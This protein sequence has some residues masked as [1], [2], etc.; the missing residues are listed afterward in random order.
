MAAYK[1]K[2]I[3]MKPVRTQP[4]VNTGQFQPS[5]VI[6][7]EIIFAAILLYLTN[8]PVNL[9]ESTLAENSAV[10]LPAVFENPATN[11]A[12]ASTAISPISQPVAK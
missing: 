11:V 4:K 7:A 6:V 1:Y 5:V 10:E 9:D 12:V 2:K 8:H 3:M